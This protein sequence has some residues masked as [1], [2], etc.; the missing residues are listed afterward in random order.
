[1]KKTLVICFMLIASGVVT[2]Q[3]AQDRR[4]E[5]NI[6]IGALGTTGD[7]EEMNWGMTATADYGW[8]FCRNFGVRGGL[9]YTWG[10]DEDMSII[11]VPI[12]FCLRTSPDRS[13]ATDRIISGVG[14]FMDR[15]NS[16]TRL[17]ENI[18]SSIFEMLPFRAELDLGFTPGYVIGHGSQG[19]PALQDNVYVNAIEVRSAIMWPTEGNAGVN[20]RRHFYLTADASIRLTFN[21]SKLTLSIVPQYHYLITHNFERCNYDWQING[22]GGRRH[23]FGGFL[24]VG[25]LF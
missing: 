15:A 9:Q 25:W 3:T 17:N 8:F 22:K 4:H 16:G 13:K 20:V 11:G 23:F 18:T 10:M 5:I 24:Q 6:G 7:Q 12:A 21:L 14:N 2:A 19:K 1:M